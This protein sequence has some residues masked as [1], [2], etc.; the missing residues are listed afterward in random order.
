MK[1][2]DILILGIILGGGYTYFFSKNT[3][4]TVN[5]KLI[6]QFDKHGIIKKNDW[7]KGKI[8]EGVQIYTSRKEYTAFQSV[9][10]LGVNEA[11]VIVLTE[12]KLP[13]AEAAIALGQCNQL[14]K[15][16]TD[17]ETSITTDAVFSVFQKALAADKDKEGVL[18]ATGDVGGKS[19]DVSARVI[20][21]VLTFSCG[22]K[23]A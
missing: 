8:I 12:G 10:N 13:K 19:Y 16:V 5:E 7:E 6:T 23:T 1:F 20:G 22:I 2:S 15:T 9:W 17:N 11:G 21:S 14:A 18:R 3:P 4:P